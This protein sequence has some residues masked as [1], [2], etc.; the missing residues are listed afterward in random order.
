MVKIAVGRGTVGRIAIENFA[1]PIV[2]RTPESSSLFSIITVVLLCSVIPLCADVTGTITTD[3]G[4]AVAGAFVR[5]VDAADSTR[6]AS[7]FTNDAGKYSLKLPD[8]GATGLRF[9][10]APPTAFAPEAKTAYG[11]LA[12]SLDGRMLEIIPGRRAGRF[13]LQR[14]SQWNPGNPDATAPPVERESEEAAGAPIKSDERGV[15]P[16]GE[17]SGAGSRF[18]ALPKASAARAFHLCVYGKGI[19][20]YQAQSVAV[21]DSSVRDFSLPATIQWDSNRAILRNNLA[22]SA[23]RFKTRK[24]GRVAF[25]G[26]SITF[27]PGWRDSVAN[28][29]KKKYPQTAFEFINAGIPSVG[30]NMHAFRFRRDVLEKGPIDLLFLE[31]A[32]NDTTNG[33]PAIERARAYEGIV[34]QAHAAN[35]AMDIVFLYFLDPSFYNNIKAGKP[36]SLITDYEKSAWQYGVS[37]LNLAQF[38]AERYTW[39]EFGGDVHPGAFGQGLYAAGIT[40]L[41]EAAWNPP[42]GAASP[43]PHNQPAR[44]QD[45]LC[46]AQGHTDSISSGVI[47]NGWKRI[48]SWKPAQGGTR[49][50]FVNVPV[51]ES[52]TPGDT[53]KFAFTG[54]AVGIVVPAGYDVGMLDYAIDGKPMGSKDQFTPWSSGLHIPWTILFSADLAAKS[55]ELRLVTSVSKNAGSQGHACR[56][57]R[58]I[59]NGPDIP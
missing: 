35:P 57:I 49:D 38:V 12:Y 9:P 22:N 6:E 52:T 2:S 24:Q 41:L 40:R 21:A 37:S 51:L 8:Q 13:L 19:Y 44:M 53:L 36:V 47:V 20:P 50:G 5:F 30:S 25:L 4:K 28:W 15:L 54:T 14:P 58:F 42:V 11:R 1:L 27:N 26:G 48:A 31:S 33:V 29:L 3:Q 39:A 32:V 7:A 55:H 23:D 18:P 56:I 45:S 46:Y 17:N 43:L 10:S 34:R 16:P 59:V